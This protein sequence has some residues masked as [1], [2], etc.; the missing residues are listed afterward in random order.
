M[1]H[2]SPLAVPGR[3]FEYLDTLIPAARHHQVVRDELHARHRVVVT[4]QG[5]H[6][7]VRTQ[8]PDLN[9]QVRRGRSQVLFVPLDVVDSLG[10]SLES[11]LKRPGV[12][13]PDFD[14]TV[15]AGRGDEV[16]VVVDRDAGDD[17]AVALES[18]LALVGYEESVRVA[19]DGLDSLAT[20]LHLFL[21]LLHLLLEIHY[22]FLQPDDRHPLLL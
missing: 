12:V 5:A 10:V 21:E 14:G 13:V 8:I 7:H 19:L 16:V 9:G 2:E 17:T 4:V 1:S 11:L 15:F 20:L 18:E 3:E 22:L 6:T